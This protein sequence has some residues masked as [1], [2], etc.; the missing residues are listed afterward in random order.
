[1]GVW[2]VGGFGVWV[3][4]EQKLIGVTLD[5]H[6]TASQLFVNYKKPSFA[7]SSASQRP[8]IRMHNNP[9]QGPDALLSLPFY[10]LLA[11]V[12]SGAS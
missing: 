5:P 3:G 6:G 1:M 10:P 11:L 8:D 12:S 7:T 2:R 4:L 9:G